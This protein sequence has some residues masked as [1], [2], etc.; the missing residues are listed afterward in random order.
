MTGKKYNPMTTE[1]VA[2]LVKK[3][4]NKFWKQ[5][6]A[7]NLR[8][9]QFED[10]EQEIWV[11][12]CRCTKSFDENNEVGAQFSTYFVRAA[13]LNIQRFFRNTVRDT[14][15]I[16]PV[17]AQDF[18]SEEGEQYEPV[19]FEV[20]HLDPE[21]HT[22]GN[23]ELDRAWNMLSPL[24]QEIISLALNPP[25]DMYEYFAAQEAHE[26]MKE[27]GSKRN[28]ASREGQF[29]F[30]LAK[31]SRY[32]QL[33]QSALTIVNQEIDYVRRQLR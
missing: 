2:L 9:L 14:I 13:M 28:A 15:E 11:T 25:Q 4:A 16:A 1:G 32:L 3:L 27:G 12:W 30:S 22:S 23:E 20:F 33:P 17:S 8:D 26:A 21:R 10:I 7:L 5:A 18:V 19:F 29:E 24:T 31:V 6:C